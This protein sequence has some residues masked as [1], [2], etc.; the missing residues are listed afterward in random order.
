MEDLNEL[1]KL[2]ERADAAG[3]DESVATLIPYIKQVETAAASQP[4]KKEPVVDVTQPQPDLAQPPVVKP[5][6]QAPIDVMGQQ[7][8]AEEYAKYSGMPIAA[9]PGEQAKGEF[10]G[11]FGRSIYNLAADLALAQGKVTGNYKEAEETAKRLREYGNNTYTNTTKGWKE[12]PLAKIQELAGGSAPYMIAPITAALGSTA[13]GVTGIAA[14]AAPMIA[15]TVQFTGSNLQRQMDQNKKLEDTSLLKA[16]GL[17]IPQA[18]LDQ[19]GF[20]FIPG[21][22]KLFGKAGIELTEEAASTLVKKSI[23]V[24]AGEKALATGKGMGVEGGTEAAQQL[25]E[26]L[27]AGLSITNAEARKEYFESFVGGAILSGG[28]GVSGQVIEGVASKLPEQKQADVEKEI[29]EEPPTEEQRPSRE[30]LKKQTLKDLE[31]EANE[32]NKAKADKA[33]RLKTAQQQQVVT[34]A[35]DLESMAPVNPTELTDTTLTSW[36][37]SKN[38]KAYKTLI[39]QD[40]GTPEGR[41]LID[42]ALEAHM[43]KINEPAVDTYKSLL[44][45]QKV[46]ATNEP[47]TDTGPG[48]DTGTIG[49]NNEVPGQPKYGTPG[50]AAGYNEPTVNISGT[51]TTLPERV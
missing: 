19:L 25:L 33:A 48:I 1:Y 50:T 45:Q 47:Q 4:A 15:S 35:T 18:A 42:T 29:I 3:D 38:S 9:K 24:R 30:T 31:D 40:A 41:T 13:L 37:L 44:D 16:G 36:G 8:S 39:G 7:F 6:I 17:A 2:L 10:S 34:E 27:Q 43:G 49:I 32:I 21:V 28:I 51:P 5:A 11:S 46:E 12:D 22:Q 20:R 14:V 23:L 26:R